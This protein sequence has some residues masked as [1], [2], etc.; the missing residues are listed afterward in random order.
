MYQQLKSLLIKNLHALGITPSRSK[1]RWPMILFP[2]LHLPS[3]NPSLHAGDLQR[4]RLSFLQQHLGQWHTTVALH[5]VVAVLVWTVIWLIVL[6]AMSHA[7][8]PKAG[9]DDNSPMLCSSH[10]SRPSTKTKSFGI[11]CYIKVNTNTMAPTSS[12]LWTAETISSFRKPMLPSMVS[13]TLTRSLGHCSWPLNWWILSISEVQKKHAG[14]SWSITTTWA[15]RFICGS[16]TFCVLALF[17]VHTNPKTLTHS[18]QP[19]V[20]EL[21]KLTA[22]IKAFDLSSDEIFTLHAF[23]ILIFGDIP[24]SSMVMQMKG[25][26][27]LVP[28]QMCKIM[29]LQTPNS[30]SPGHYIPLSK[31]TTQSPMFMTQLISLC[32]PMPIFSTLPALFKW[33][34]Q[35]HNQ[36]FLQRIQA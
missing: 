31:T 25:H 28:C 21:L 17:L 8:I 14:Q 27:G 5:H 18:F 26:N 1:P 36:I 30:H 32:A 19:L 4:S 13:L 15:W 10:G 6:I 16:I 24:V 11:P 7:S 9:H 12:M 2:N 20:K 33:L 29:A 23:L 34:Q 3:P 22:G 35:Q